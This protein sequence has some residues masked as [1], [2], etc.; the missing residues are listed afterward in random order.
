MATRKSSSPLVYITNKVEQR[1]HFPN[2]S[3]A[4]NTIHTAV[5]NLRSPPRQTPASTAKQNKTNLSQGRGARLPERPEVEV[6]RRIDDM[7]NRIGRE[8]N[9]S[10]SPGREVRPSAPISRRTH[11]CWR[12]FSAYDDQIESDARPESETAARKRSVAERPSD[13]SRSSACGGSRRSASQSRVVRKAM[14]PRERQSRRS[15]HQSS[16][17][18]SSDAQTPAGARNVQRRQEVAPASSRRTS[19]EQHWEASMY[20][21]DQPRDRFRSEIHFGASELLLM[22]CGSERTERRCAIHFEASRLR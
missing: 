7:D 16:T 19:R 22:E 21:R 3:N 1:R 9:A 12:A 8:A 20:R 5:A 10:A 11:H 13:E 18:R 4:T 15:G 14:S 2:D 6:R 17:S